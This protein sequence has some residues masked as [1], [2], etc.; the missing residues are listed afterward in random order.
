MKS[1]FILPLLFLVKLFASFE[2]N[3][4][5]IYKLT[6]GSETIINDVVISAKQPIQILCT[7]LAFLEFNRTVDKEKA[8]YMVEYHD[9][10]GISSEALLHPI[11]KVFN[12]NKLWEARLRS[13]DMVRL[14]GRLMVNDVIEDGYNAENYTVYQMSD[15][16]LKDPVGDVFL[17]VFSFILQPVNG[18][19]DKVREEATQNHMARLMQSAEYYEMLKVSIGESFDVYECIVVLQQNKLCDLWR[20]MVVRKL[21]AADE[22]KADEEKD[23][24]LGSNPINDDDRFNY[25]VPSDIVN[26]K[27]TSFNES[28]GEFTLEISMPHIEMAR[29][30]KNTKFI[31]KS[32][33]FEYLTDVMDK[34]IRLYKVSS[35]PQVLHKGQAYSYWRD[36][37]F[38]LN[39]A[40]SL[41]K[42]ELQFEN[43]F[44][45]NNE[46]D[47][48]SM[49]LMIAVLNSSSPVSV[50]RTQS[51]DD[52]VMT[53]STT[54]VTKFTEYGMYTFTLGPYSRLFTC[55]LQKFRHV[56]HVIDES[57]TGQFLNEMFIPEVKPVKSNIFN[58]WFNGL[59]NGHKNKIMFTTIGFMFVLTIIIV[60]ILCCCCQTQGFKCAF[61]CCCGCC[62]NDDAE[63]NIISMTDNSLGNGIAANQ[64]NGPLNGRISNQYQPG[65]IQQPWMNFQMANQTMA[66][67]AIFSQQPGNAPLTA[68]G[69]RTEAKLK[70]SVRNLLSQLDTFQTKKHINRN[71]LESQTFYNLQIER[72][73]AECKERVAA[74]NLEDFSDDDKDN[75][76]KHKIVSQEELDEVEN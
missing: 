8:D 28:T 75:L 19:A 50:H 9:T 37:L 1:Q 5:A 71:D 56:H 4:S 11:S 44:I 18:Y 33:D 68:G 31:R 60:I 16:Q 2:I 53:I 32:V 59:R 57:Q 17:D 7:S 76:L 23:D 55:H 35:P 6:N 51:E 24:R 72:L 54:G 10:M 20:E 21:V 46:Y 42:K 73:I 49:N 38:K 14:C 12:N 66:N 61:N 48:D 52:T 47:L 58:N 13:L 65:F 63:K 62:C 36:G 34:H 29:V 43:N 41:S 26:L 27:D 40:R 3:Q 15:F 25:W 64:A 74:K 67:P 39:K 70:R 45:C 22:E 69:E 30:G